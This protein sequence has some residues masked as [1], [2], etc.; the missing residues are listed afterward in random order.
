MAKVSNDKLRACTS[1]PCE[2]NTPN[3]QTTQ[4]SLWDHREDIRSSHGSS[5]NPCP[6]VVSPRVLYGAASRKT[7]DLK[8]ELK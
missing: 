8:W 4:G 6:G 2:P 5:Q 7:A 1:N 3:T